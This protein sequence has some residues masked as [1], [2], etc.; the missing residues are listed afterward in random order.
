MQNCSHRELVPLS[1]TELQ[2][3]DGGSIIG[4]LEKIAAFID[5]TIAKYEALSPEAKQDLRDHFPMMFLIFE[6]L[7]AISG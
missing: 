6:V 2:N 3:I 5:T 7:G 4:T 1:G